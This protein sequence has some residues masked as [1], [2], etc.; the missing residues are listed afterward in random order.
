MKS[1]AEKKKSQ[2]IGEY[3]IYMYQMEDLI[4]SFQG[5]MD[6]IRQYVISHYPVADEEKGRAYAAWSQ[7]G[8]NGIDTF[9]CG[10]VIERQSDQLGIGIDAACDLADQLKAAR[11]GHLPKHRRREEQDNG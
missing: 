11:L 5:N 2:N 9:R 4:R 8:Q 6:E 10:A 3:L 7:F 1:V